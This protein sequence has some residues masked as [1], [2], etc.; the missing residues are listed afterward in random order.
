M[1]VMV[2]VTI[3]TI[4]VT[5]GIV[6]LLTTNDAY[7]K[8]QTERQVVD[9]LGFTLESM[10]R[11]LRTARQWDIGNSTP[12]SFIFNDQY[13]TRVEYYLDFDAITNT[14][15]IFR[16]ITNSNGVASINRITPETIDVEDLVFTLFETPGTIQPYLQ[17]QIR[18]VMKTGRQESL[19]SIQTGVS[20]RTL[21]N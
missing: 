8:S 11:S 18:G 16:K 15:V 10:S 1:E 7:K 21:N 13:N 19:F 3:F 5:V 6:A 14:G 4:I 2:A 17:I 9:S 12:I 20:K